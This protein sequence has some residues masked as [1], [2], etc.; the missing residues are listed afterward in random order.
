[1]VEAMLLIKMSENFLQEGQ[2]VKEA[3]GL[4]SKEERGVKKGKPNFLERACP[5]RPKGGE[6]R[7]P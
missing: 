6:Q 1:M 3:P 7:M 2:S 4:A 5:V